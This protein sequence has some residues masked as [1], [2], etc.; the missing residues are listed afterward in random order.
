MSSGF[1]HVRA[2]MNC[3]S[4]VAGKIGK[5]C[6]FDAVYEGSP[7][8]QKISE[9]AI[10]GDATPSGQMTIIGG[11]LTFIEKGDEYYIDLYPMGHVDEPKQCYRENVLKI[12]R[13]GIRPD[14]NEPWQPVQFRFNGA[15]GGAQISLYMAIANPAA[16]AFL[17]DSDGFAIV[18]HRASGRRSDE[19]IALRQ[20]MVDDAR[21]DLEKLDPANKDAWRKTSLESYIAGLE[22]K[23]ARAKGLEPEYTEG[24]S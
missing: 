11:G 1:S 9:N 7:E 23:L 19:E 4:A 16:V 20:K 14:T 21:A 8:L 10:F 2:K 24:A 15:R 17:D 18:V 12:F 13:S 5:I 22:K 6:E 3:S